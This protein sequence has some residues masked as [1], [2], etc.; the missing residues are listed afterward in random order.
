DRQ[1]TDVHEISAQTIPHAALGKERRA[2]LFL[3]HSDLKAQSLGRLARAFSQGGALDVRQH[4]L[5]FRA[6]RFSEGWR[7]GQLLLS[8]KAPRRREM[9]N[10][11][12]NDVQAQQ[13]QYYVEVPH[14]IDVE[15]TQSPVD[16]LFRGRQTGVIIPEG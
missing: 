15:E 13:Q 5:V 9:V 10:R 11:G 6:L 14:V 2:L 16:D 3:C 8:D 7:S 12:E 4:D 1:Q